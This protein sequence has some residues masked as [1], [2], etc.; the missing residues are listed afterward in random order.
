MVLS[1]FL[2][3]N[4]TTIVKAEGALRD[5]LLLILFIVI[6]S[7]FAWARQR[8][9]LG[10]GTRTYFIQNAGQWDDP[11]LFHSQ[12]SF[13]AF[14]AEKNGYTVNLFDHDIDDEEALHGHHHYCTHGH[15]YRVRYKNCNPS[16]SVSGLDI[17]SDG[18]YDN[19][20]LGNDPAR[21]VSRLPHFFTLFYSQLYSGI[22]MDIR[23]SENALKS[24]Y[25]VSP[26]ADPTQI[27]M[28]YEG[29][30]KIY[31]SNGNLIIRTTVG[32]IVELAPYAYQTCDTGRCE[33]ECRYQIRGNEV[34]FVL[35]EYDNSHPLTIDPILYFS[36]Y[37]GSTVDNWGTTATFDL[38]KN[39]Y[40]A[41]I[42]FG[43]GYPVSSG[44]WRQTH[45]GNADIG[46]FKFDPTGRHRLFATYLG[47]QNADMPHSMFVNSFDELVIFGTTGSDDFPVLMNAYQ[48]HF[49]GGSHV[50]YEGSNYVNFPNGS[51]IF[52]S[53]FSSDG[54]ALQASTFVGGSGN[55]GLNYRHS[56]SNS[57]LYPS[58]VIMCGNDSLYFNYGDGARGELITDDLNNIYVGSTTFSTNF[59]VTNNSVST[60]HGGGQ[61]GVVFK[62]DYNLR[63]MIW[64]TYLG[65]S[66]DDAVYSI[67]VDSSYNLLVCGGTNSSDFPTTTGAFQTAF[68]GGSA[69]GFVAKISYN[70]EVL[71]S[72]S[73]F[74]TPSYDQMYFVRTGKQNDVFLY[75]QTKDNSNFF[76]HNANYNVPGAGM[77]VAR[78]NPD[79]TQ[80]IWSTTFGNVT[81][82]PN[83]SPTAFA[84]DI[85]N[86]IYISGWG[87]DYV[88]SCNNVDW[89]QGGTTGMEITPDAYQT[90]TDGQDFYIMSMDADASGINYATY[91]GEL[92][93]NHS[94]NYAIDAASGHD[95]VDGGT[96]RFDRHA[97]LYQSV[98]ASCSRN[99]YFPVT[100]SVWGP[101]NLSSDNCNNALFRFNIHDDFPV[102][103]CVAPEV[104]CA[105]YDVT[106]INTGRGDRYFWDFGDG[107]TSTLANPQH[108]YSTSGTFR[109]T[110]VAY[111]DQG[112]RTTDT[113]Y[114]YVRVLSEHGSRSAT[115]S[116]CSTEPTQIGPTPMQGCTY[117]WIQGEV[118]DP[119]IANPYVTHGG[120]YI[121]RITS[122][123][124]C[125]ETDTFDVMIYDIIDTLII[126]TPTCPGGNDGKAIA[127]VP[128]NISDSAVYYWDGVIGDSILTGLSDDGQQHTLHIESH[129]CETTIYFTVTDPPVLEHSVSASNIIC[130]NECNGWITVDYG[131][132]GRPTSTLSLDG[133]CDSTYIIQ[134]TDT[135]GCPYSDTVTIT[136]DTSLTH[137]QVWADAYYIYLSQS[138]GLHVTH[139]PGASYHWTPSNT[140]NQPYSPDPIATP[141]DSI[142][143]YHVIVTDSNGC[144][145]EG[146]VVINCTE[147]NC[148]RP[149][150]F[151][152]NAFS[153]NGDGVNDR[154][155]FHGD[156]VTDFY[157][158]IYSRW[159]EKVYE[160]YDIHDCWDG[161]YNGN[162]CLPGV[163]AYYCKVRC[164]AGFENLLKGDITLIR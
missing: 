120:I 80:R 145:W 143:I 17:D 74:G 97:T 86:R 55:D 28:Q 27:V 77:V 150:I 45:S 148:G 35:G 156:Y 106:F 162:W 158:A 137:L 104:G 144:S 29:A 4:S 113:F 16:P 15:A 18:G 127:I 34:N 102:A 103:E 132:P 24:N 160:T 131:Y 58:S 31:I 123:S 12:M 36:T 25:Y 138:V 81:G 52:I 89:N 108:T 100:D 96:S 39:A 147:I 66:G 23:V 134:F 6:T 83:I 105:P 54:T 133:L 50:A 32:E 71:M 125:T 1:K 44:A 154:L 126:R 59:P 95:H 53:R 30:D 62:I 64:S 118:S 164:E 155:C 5:T 93:G 3:S 67:D 65:G 94:G 37:T 60:T 19:Y 151:I 61:E 122:N 38:Y 149:N 142:Q 11:S 109:A 107:T 40:T 119:T 84:A 91:F 49:R 136:R 78:F 153:P 101:H 98:C 124:G 128:S 69:D 48:N 92:H 73:Y 75:G 88:G 14:F 7:P 63:N 76:I 130:G 85:C 99:D 117:E 47:G 22:D 8:D 56:F 129:G 157:L 111:M 10:V 13:P 87:R 140:I 121:L 42:V 46:I 21:W 161:R 152:P 163:Y 9:T 146:N 159:G 116:T 139:V 90:H 20:Y 82:R 70:G 114:V 43:S 72:S 135:A 112:C 57:Q 110:L 41:G 68:G 51:D 141:S 115:Q 33:I 2:D 26:H 79:I